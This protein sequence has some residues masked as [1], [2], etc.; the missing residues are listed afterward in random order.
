MKK[1]GYFAEGLT[2]MA[3][4][5]IEE[6]D[7]IGAEI[8]KRYP[9]AVFF[10][11]QLVFAKETLWTKWLHNFTVFALQRKFYNQGIPF[12]ILPIRV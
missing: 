4:D 7:K 3:T 2:Y 1:Q 12:V 8:Y 6:I 9:N 5:V 10:G 11:G